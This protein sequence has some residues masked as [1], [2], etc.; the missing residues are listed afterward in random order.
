MTRFS[1]LAA[2]G[3]CVCFSAHAQST[4]L[5]CGNIFDA[6]TAKLTGP[7]QI[8]IENGKI[9][10]IQAQVSPAGAAKVVD[11]SRHTC[12]PGWIDLHVHLGS[13]SSPSSYSEGFRLDEVD[14]AFRAVGYAEKTLMAG[15]TTVRDLG[16][17]ISPHLRDAVNQGLVKGPRILAA[18]KSIATTGG[19]ADPTNGYNSA[20]SHVVGPP[21]PTQ[22]VINSVDDARQAV[23]QRYKEGSDVI[24]ITAT[25]GVL[26]YAK[27]ADAPQFTVDEVKAIVDTAK[28]YGY[29]VAAHAHGTEG[30]KRAILGGVTSIEHGTYMTDEVMR[31]MKE[32]GTWYVPTVSAG[33]FV[34]EKAKE[35][36]FYP[37]I[38]RPKAARIGAQIEATFAKAYKA[39]VPI[40][41]GTDSGVSY[42]GTNAEEFIYMT[43][44]GMPANVALQTATLNA[45]KVL[46]ITDIGQLAT[47]FK[48]DVVAVPGDPI[49]DITLVRKVDFIMKDG[50]I[51]KQP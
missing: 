7:A 25:G 22:G 10:A 45:A 44:A 50:V 41:F 12:L 48:A 19:H 17:E 42:H 16:G 13:E 32:R 9:S 29:T 36:G 27:S 28:D 24:K 14:F 51:Y 23:R 20:L 35:D 30:M 8:L 4:V 34:A 26:S 49:A 5:R 37:E 11:L 47:E 2:L 21:G 33:R 38:V 18:G 6:K 31:L 1:L 39:G 43:Q 15:F 3:L 40:A 46:N